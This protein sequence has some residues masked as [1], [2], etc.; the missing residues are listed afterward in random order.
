MATR[1]SRAAV[2]KLT[3]VEFAG[4]GDDANALVFCNLLKEFTGRWLGAAVIDDDKFIEF[5]VGFF[6]NAAQTFLEQAGLIASRN[7]DGGH[8][9]RYCVSHSLKLN[10]SADGLRHYSSLRTIYHR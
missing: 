5:V 2:A 7:N 3:V 8:L 10:F 6:F 1:S 4:D 9:H